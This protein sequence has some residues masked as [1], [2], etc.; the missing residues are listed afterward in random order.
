MDY[1]DSESYDSDSFGAGVAPPHVPAVGYNSYG[2]PSMTMNTSNSHSVHEQSSE[3]EEEDEEE[4]VPSE[5]DEGSDE[6]DSDEEPAD[7]VAAPVQPRGKTFRP[8]VGGGDS[9]SSS[10]DDERDPRPSPGNNNHAIAT[11]QVINPNPGPPRGKELRLIMKMGN[12]DSSDDEPLASKKTRGSK[13][14]AA[15][16]KR[17]APAPKK[18]SAKAPVKKSPSKATAASRKR[19]APSPA[20]N[21]SDT[22]SDDDDDSDGDACIAT[23]VAGS[24]S[25][26]VM[27][28]AT[29]IK[30]SKGSSKKRTSSKQVA[31]RKAAPKKGAKRPS[32]SA[33]LHGMPEISAEKAAAAWEARKTL[34]EAIT[35][36]PHAVADSHT[37][38]SFGRIKPEYNAAPL[39]ALYSSPLSIY[40]VGFS[41]DRFEFSPVHGRVIKMRCDILDGSSLREYRE[42]QAKKDGP[43]RAKSESGLEPALVDEKITS[44]KENVEN[45]GDGPVF[46]V[47]WGEGVDEDKVLEPSCPF[48]PY[49]ASAHLGGDVDAIAVP[50]SSKKGNKPLGFPEVGMR[51]SVRFDKCKKYGG[52]ITSVKPIEKQAKNG[53][54]AICNITIQ[55]DDGVTEVAVFPDP[56]IVVAYQGELGDFC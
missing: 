13:P 43:T 56:D 2:R 10:S 5:D 37:I 46:R 19:K 51:V 40:P 29:N 14:K 3:D 48:D 34:Q 16:R 47:T 15:T 39:D 45:L 7:A 38:R 6:Y 24:D 32:P 26:D 44:E 53:K 8:P 12:D 17:S 49:I 28:V 30:S 25:E 36:L 23:I 9:D 11:A 52:S 18:S 50:L 22:G 42:E 35:S 55:Y 41:C 54:N 33:G 4:D 27:A 20:D 1:S 21:G 31:A